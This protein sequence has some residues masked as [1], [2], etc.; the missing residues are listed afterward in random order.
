MIHEENQTCKSY[1]SLVVLVKKL[2]ASFFGIGD[3]NIILVT[4]NFL[5]FCDDELFFDKN[6]KS[7]AHFLK[8]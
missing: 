1:L 3:F 8:I 5:K 4:D 6:L 7:K 2:R